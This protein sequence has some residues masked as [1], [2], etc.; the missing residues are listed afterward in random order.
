MQQRRAEYSRQTKETDIRVKIDLDG[1]SRLQIQ[2]GL[3]WADHMLTLL[4]FWA[5]FDLEIQAQGDLEVDGHHTLE[6]TGLCLGEALRRA[7]G[8]KAGLARV[9]WAKVPMDE[10]LSEVVLDISGRPYLVYQDQVLP[11]LIFGQEKDLWREFFKSLAFRAGLNMHII[12]HYGQNGHHLLES[13]C[14]ALGLA[15]GQGL[16]LQQSGIRSS[17]GSLD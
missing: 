9:G 5:G 1:E 4:G 8:D 13:G 14:K 2:T 17:K 16:R 11:Q 7:I 15:L 10:A 3:G 12:F 6:D